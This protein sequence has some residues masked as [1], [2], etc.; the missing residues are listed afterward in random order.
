[1]PGKVFSPARL[2]RLALENRIVLSPMTRMQAGEDGTPGED[3]ARYY[4]RYAGNGVGLVMTEAAYVDDAQSR[5]YFRQPGMTNERH[6][7]GWRRVVDAVHKAG[8]PILLQLQHGGRLAEPGLH[9]CA[10]GATGRS[11]AGDSWQ[12]AKSY[13]QSSV[14]AAS[15]GEL[16]DV[17]GAFAAATR[18]ARA[19]GFDGVEIHGARGYLIDE[20]LCRPGVELAERLAFPLAVVRAARSAFPE[21]VLSFNLSLYKMDDIGYQ[22]PGGRDEVAAIVQALHAENLDVLHVTTRRVLRPEAFG[23]PLAVVVREAF[24]GRSLIVNGGIRSLQDAEDA[25]AQ[26]GAELVALA[27]ALLANPDWVR[28]TRSGEPLAPYAPGM[29]RLPLAPAE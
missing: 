9:P 19:A 7:A 24:P 16:A 15:A 4:A 13:A 23:A 5:A 22:P 12:G 14:R 11:A 28:R 26:T 10:I 1:V 21:G 8:R 20:V 25:L 3:M 29:E 17:A 6:Q 18:H 2:G 27:R